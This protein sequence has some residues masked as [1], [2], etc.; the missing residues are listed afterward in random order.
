MTVT[1]H[2][3][4]ICKH[5]DG[6]LGEK[7]NLRPSVISNI[8][9]AIKDRASLWMSV[10]PPYEGGG[11]EH[12]Y[13]YMYFSWNATELYSVCLCSWQNT[14]VLSLIDKAY[15]AMIERQNGRLQQNLLFITALLTLLIAALGHTYRQ[16]EELADA[17]NHL[18][19][20]NR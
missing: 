6:S 14:N 4:L 18:Q 20:A 10:Q 7:Q 9:S 17:G 1:Y 13:Q 15:Q 16:M 19:V 8:C 11:I 12:A 3:S 2:H 5:S